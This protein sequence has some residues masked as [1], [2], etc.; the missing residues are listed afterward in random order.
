MQVVPS[1][2][3]EKYPALHEHTP[4]PILQLALVPH[5]AF[6]AHFA[7]QFLP[8]PVGEKSPGRHEHESTGLATEIMPV[9]REFVPHCERQV[10]T[11]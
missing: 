10:V 7:M 11:K 3:G 5:P 2:F 1:E 8:L 6:D 4:V 9:Q